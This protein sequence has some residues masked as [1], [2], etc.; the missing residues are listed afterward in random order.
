[1]LT[2]GFRSKL[3]SQPPLPSLDS[4]DALHPPAYL[5]RG[6]A[7][8]EQVPFLVGSAQAFTHPAGLDRGIQVPDELGYLLEVPH[9]LIRSFL[10]ENTDVLVEELGPG[11][12][13]RFAGGFVRLVKPSPELAQA[14]SVHARFESLHVPPDLRRE[15]VE[16]K[17]PVASRE[18]LSPRFL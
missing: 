17:R 8:Q 14:E 11:D 16:T 15:L 5:P 4:K 1:M 13:G 2:L 7:H 18:I 12:S 6:K 3:T 9:D 10:A